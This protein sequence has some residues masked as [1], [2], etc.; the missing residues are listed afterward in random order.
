MSRLPAAGARP[1]SVVMRVR[2]FL[3]GLRRAHAV[4]E[5][6]VALLCA[7]LLLGGV[8]GA[9]AA[10]ASPGPAW[11]LCGDGAGGDPPRHDCDECRL[12]SAAFVALVSEGN[13]LRADRSA[14][15]LM[16]RQSGKLARH[17]VSGTSARGPP[18]GA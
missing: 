4:R 10:A 5:I 6:G 16:A 3:A 17:R 8:A 18:V 9:R 2:L 13:V 11:M 12:G 7:L 1:K 14:L 15:P